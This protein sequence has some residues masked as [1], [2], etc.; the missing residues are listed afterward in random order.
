VPANGA[1]TA[2]WDLRAAGN[3]DVLQAVLPWLDHYFKPTTADPTEELWAQSLRQP[4]SARALDVIV[5][6]ALRVLWAE[7]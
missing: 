2:Y 6:W 4:I 3:D 1:L 7:R 5:S